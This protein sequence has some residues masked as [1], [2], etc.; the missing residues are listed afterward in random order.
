M[1]R[2]TNLTIPLLETASHFTNHFWG[3]LIEFSQNVME[4][5]DIHSAEHFIPPQRL[6]S[7]PLLLI[8]PSWPSSSACHRLSRPHQ[9]YQQ[10]MLA[11]FWPLLSP[12]TFSTEVQLIHFHCCQ[13]LNLNQKLRAQ[14]QAAV[15]VKGIKL[16][17]VLVNWG[18]MRFCSFWV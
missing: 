9:I 8:P 6:A 17:N 3:G 1:F 18:S 2:L 13:T 15:Q 4:I 10:N 11:L 16:A 7:S 5:S 14:N 12:S